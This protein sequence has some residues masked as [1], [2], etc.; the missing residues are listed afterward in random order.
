MCGGM[1]G[2]CWESGV[3][4]VLSDFVM[5]VFCGYFDLLD[6]DVVLRVFFCGGF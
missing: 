1:L 4:W 3:W 6:W 5:V 2:F